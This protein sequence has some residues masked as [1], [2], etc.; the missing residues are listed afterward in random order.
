MSGADI[1]DHL[2]RYIVEQSVDAILCLQPDGR[3][4]Y[5]NKTAC[6]SLGYTFD[7]LT[8]LHVWDINPDI[9]EE[10]WPE[11]WARLE[12]QKGVIIESRHRTRD[13]DLF[14]VEVAVN[15]FTVNGQGYSCA[16]VRDI[17]DQKTLQNALQEQLEFFQTT[18]NAI[19]SPMY[20]KDRQGIFQGVNAAFEDFIGVD[21][22]KILKKTI[23]DI[24]PPDKLD[25]YLQADEEIYQNPGR[26]V[27]E[28]LVETAAG[29]TRNV[30]FSRATYEDRQGDVA[31]LIG[32]MFD[33]TERKQAETAQKKSEEQYR[34]LLEFLPHM[35]AVH[36]DEK[37]VYM[38]PAGLELLGVRDT[39]EILGRSAWE[40][41]LPENV[42]A[43]KKR[44]NN[45][46]SA[47]ATLTSIEQRLRG[48]DGRV[49]DVRSAGSLI[50]YNGAPAILFVAENITEKKRQEAELERYRAHLEDLVAERTAQILTAKEQLE[51]EVAER[52]RAQEAY[53]AVVDHSLQGL[54]IIQDQRI[55][56]ANPALADILGYSIKEM[57]ELSADD[58]ARLILPLDR[59]R[60]LT[61]YEELLDGKPVTEFNEYQLLRKD[62]RITWVRVYASL[63]NYGGRPAMQ[64]AIMDI[65][66]AREAEAE[67]QKITAELRRSNAELEQFAYAASHD[68]QEP[69]RKISGFSSLLAEEYKGKLSSEADEYIWFIT[70][71]VKRM[72]QLI[73]GTSHLFP[74]GQG[75]IEPGAG[76]SG[77]CFDYRAFRPSADYRRKVRPSNS[78]S[79]AHGPGQPGADQPGASESYY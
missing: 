72:R 51:E 1:L 25:S 13:G 62:G 9:T 2:S 39:R 77:R 38:N 40:I 75:G 71:A 64:E 27:F 60:I 58:V 70:D 12:E 7:Q 21:R 33:I 31:G 20:I 8:R 32:I 34:R 22:D 76:S 59:K 78:Q 79:L 35:V 46:W 68:L 74:R 4:I 43:I 36:Q 48:H 65:T 44:L 63:I 11:N 23:S 3:I 10:Q 16:H 26:Q 41:I 24:S 49:V 56:F 17:S 61:H 54:V 53:Q 29:D 50:E 47:G 19:P 14:P 73:E 55:V 42:D 18:L 52:T 6:Q 28:G 69:L 15:H 37:W 66:A 30:I 45:I 57:L 67:L 5:V